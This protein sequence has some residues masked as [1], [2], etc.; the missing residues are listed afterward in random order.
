[1][2]TEHINYK[3]YAL[4]NT[5]SNEIRYIGLTKNSLNARLSKHLR[6]KYKTYKTNWINSN[7]PNIGIIL[8]EENIRTKE[9]AC[10]RE[11]FY[12]SKLKE[13]GYKLVNTTNGGDG[14]FHTSLSKK[15]REN[16]S[17][18][19]ANVSGENNPMYGKKHTDAVKNFS[20]ILNSGRKHSEDTILFFSK[21][22]TGSGNQ[23]S[24]LNEK[25][26]LEIR[27]LF[28]TGCYSKKE[29]S[30]IFGVKPPAIYKIVNRL[31]WK[32]I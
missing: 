26:V 28:K 5:I 2:H 16:I 24:L 29:L 23:N 9:E 20:K 17:K 19:H 11:I 10:S 6:D 31:T 3:I 30:N 25:L 7:K 13:E 14:W 1:M 12:I 21:T 4:I 15:H 32:H 22:R 8:I 27:E 18:N